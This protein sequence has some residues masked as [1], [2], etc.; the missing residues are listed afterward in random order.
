MNGFVA[1][2]RDVLRIALPLLVSSGSFSL[3]LFADRTMLMWYD[4]N[5]MENSMAAS[6]TAGNVF[7]VLVCLPVG[8]ASMTGAITAQYV[9]SGQPHR[10]GRLLWQSLWL[11][12]L[13]VPLL[14]AAA[15]F[16]PAIFRATGQ[17]ESMVPAESIYLQLLMIGGLG[18]I[19]ESALSGFFSGTERTSV[20]M[21]TSVASAVL[22]VALDYW[23]IFGGLGLP[24]YGIEGAAV[25]SSIAFWFKAVVYASLLSARRWETVYA[26]RGGFGWDSMLLGKLFYFGLPAGLFQV[27]E[28]GGF[29]WILLRIGA[30]GEEPIRATTMAIN[31]NMVAYI[32]LVGL[33]VAASVLVGRH[34]TESGPDRA[35]AAVR[36]AL[37]VAGIYC[38]LWGA[39][40]LSVPHWLIAVYGDQDQPSVR[41][42]AEF[43]L[44]VVTGYM[45]LDAIQVTLAGALRGAGDTWF[46]LG[47]LLVV[48]GVVLGAASLL[49]DAIIDAAQVDPLYYWWGV[50]YAWIWMLGIVL[51]LRYLQGRWRTMRMVENAPPAP[52]ATHV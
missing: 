33:Q 2:V 1:N 16:A 40:Y 11:A 38:A 12:I 7:W 34:L 27:A 5:A 39:V 14:A 21:Y 10:I 17:P 25:A 44:M 22:N 37:L 52:L 9:G 13:C 28:A 48:G 30:L 4:E 51:G 46:V 20:I 41:R 15:Y 3:V 23:L 26:I 29:T 31:Y 19:I 43:L 49:E 42:T 18:M 47:A 24:A 6:M 36:A 32:P 45:F 8:I 50:L 35:A